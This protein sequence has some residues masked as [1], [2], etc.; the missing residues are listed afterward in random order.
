MTCRFQPYDVETPFLLP[1][2]LQDWLPE[3][4]LAYF[5]TDAVAQL[6]LAALYD[7]YRA[8]GKGQTPYHP[9]MMVTVLLYAYCTGVRS[10]RQIEKKCVEDIAF[11]VLAGN[12]KPD[13]SALCRFRERHSLAL[14]ELFLQVLRLCAEAG[15]VR[16]GLLALD[17]VKLK[18]NAAL[19]ANRTLVG[20]RKEIQKLLA[21]A[22]AEDRREDELF[23]A[24]R[25]GD[26]VPAELR[27]RASR[28][29]RLTECRRR[30]EEEAQAAEAAQAAKQAARAAKEEAQGGKVRGRKPLPPAAKVDA[31]AKANVTDPESRIMKTRTGYVQGY[32]AQA[33]C[34]AA[35]FIV[36]AD[37]TVEEND[38]RQLAPLLEQAR[39]NLKVAGA[40][41]RA[42]AA[43][44]DAGYWSAKNAC[45]GGRW[46]PELFIATQKDWKQRAA[47][48]R[49]AAPRGRRPK[50]LSVR[51]L[52]DRKLLTKRGR[53]LYRKRGEMIEAVFG[54]V[55]V[56][57]DGKQCMRRGQAAARSEW[58]LTCTGHNLL[59]LWRSGRARWN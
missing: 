22:Q 34:N 40:K 46:G 54:Q 27:K 4:H 12:Q 14:E 42:R 19:S 25:R 58:R 3:E 5:L 39:H 18:A 7:Y 6:D 37:V 53:H 23:G 17:G 2:A 47:L 49:Q 57:Q 20:L 41:G 29:V 33:V 13:H 44:A 16:A 26:E 9:R 50:N 1:P 28:R 35:Q 59:K 51:E 10:S 55:T 30:L 31:E 52:M 56:V 36:A 32:N 48:R 45:W 38:K 15:L 43:L 8:D 24:E 11:R 21:E